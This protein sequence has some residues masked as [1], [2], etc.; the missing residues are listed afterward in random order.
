VLRVPIG[1]N[2]IDRLVRCGSS[3]K[4]GTAMVDASVLRGALGEC[5]AAEVSGIAY[6]EAL[7]QRF[8]AHRDEFDTLAL[9]ERTTSELI[10]A[11]AR[12]CNVTIDYGEAVVG[13]ERAQIVLFESV[14]AGRPE[15]WSAIDAFLERHAT[16]PVPRRT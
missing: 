12:S 7:G 9:V 8:P 4:G 6:Y 16:D 14:V 15:D 10:E 5:W 3:Q 1:R 2:L 13:H 11:V